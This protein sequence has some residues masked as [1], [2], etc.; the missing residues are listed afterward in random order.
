[1][2]IETPKNQATAIPRDPEFDEFV[3]DE[4]LTLRHYW[5]L[6]WRNKWAISGLVFAVGL[7]TLIWTY[8]LQPIYRS[9]ATLMIGANEPIMESEQQSS[10]N[11]LDRE[12]FLGTQYELLKSREIAKAALEKLKLDQQSWFDPLGEESKSRFNWRNWIPRAWLETMDVAYTPVADSDPDKAL[13]G[14]LRKNLQIRPVQHTSLAEVSFETTNPRMAS[15]VANAVTQAYIETNLKQRHES[16]QEA[17]EWLKQQ[18]LKSQHN[19]SES[20]DALQKYREQTGLVEVEGMQ[21][22]YT[23]HLKAVASEYASARQIR[24]EAE[25]RYQRAKRLKKTGQLDAMSG[26]FDNPWVQHLR[27]QENKLEREIRLDSERFQGNYPE[28]DEA[29]QNLE[30]IRNHIDEVFGQIVEGFRTDYELALSNEEHLLSER[31]KL[32]DKVQ[33]LN[34]K[35]FQVDAL[36]RAVATNRQSYDAFLHRLMDMSTL[37]ADTVSMIARIVDPAVPQFTP[38]KPNKRRIMTIAVILALFAGVGIVLLLDKLDN[39]LKRREEVE[40]RLGIPVLGELALLKNKRNDGT[41]IVPATEFLDEPKSVFAESIRT[42]RTSVALSGLDR[43]RQVIV[44]T[45][46]V[47]GEGKTTVALNLALS[48]GQLGNVLLIDADLRR[49]SLAKLSGLKTKLP[50]LTDVVA[51]TAK[52]A[53]CIHRIAGDIHLLPVGSVIPPDPLKALSSERFSELLNKSATAY[54]SVVIDSAPIEVVSDARVLATNASGVVYV[55][56]A[57]E[58]PHQAVRQGLNSLKQTNA[59]VIGAVLNQL[60]PKTSRSYDKYKYGYSRYAHYHY[61]Q[62][63]YS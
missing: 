55:I 10:A 40:E 51:S 26:V 63:A 39:T 62:N 3:E 61:S 6:V 13:L 18:L 4:G 59:P 36:E 7:F 23:E 16:S 5:Y 52:V 54:D 53:D 42:F 31:K 12:K 46:T 9:T 15:Q 56:K 30:A 44:V 38:V 8:S 28:L 50:G 47:S 32:E 33:E 11:G 21:S 37:G 14:W 43:K 49:P 41:E 35:G 1:M 48:L 29:K 22:V 27:E 58:T 20:I 2:M 34:E 24:T 19:V 45:S 57:D 17:S 60:D 25:N